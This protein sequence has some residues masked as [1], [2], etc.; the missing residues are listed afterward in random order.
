MARYLLLV[1]LASLSFAAFARDDFACAQ[2]QNEI[3]S[4]KFTVE[5]TQRARA[6]GEDMAFRFCNGHAST[7]LLVR[8]KAKGKVRAVTLTQEQSTRLLALYETALEMNFK[9]EDLGLDGAI[10]CLET[11]RGMN[12]LRACFWSP[13]NNTHR[14]GLAG[15]LALGTTLWELAGFDKNLLD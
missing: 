8:A 9:D 2:S 13:A 4:E 12:S 7:L 5:I 1:A 15:L 3:L 6:P 14:R 10:W 11:K